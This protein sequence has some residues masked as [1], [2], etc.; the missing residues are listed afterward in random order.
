MN[1]VTKIVAA[2]PVAS[3]S[4]A[5]IAIKGKGKA[6]REAAYMQIAPLSFVEALSRNESVANLRVAL[7]VS[8]SADEVKAAQV[9]WVIGRVASRL[10][11]DAFPKGD[12]S[13]SAKLEHARNLVVSYASPAQDGKAARA[14]RKG[15]LGRRTVTQHKVIRAAEEAWSLI[16]AELGQ[17]NAQTQAQRNALKSDS[18]KGKGAAMAG[19][20]K[21]K[22][23]DLSAA[24]TTPTHAELVKPSV[25]LSEDDACSYIMTQAATLLAYANK[26]AKVIPTDFGAAI[27]ALKSAVNK[28]ENARQVRKI[29]KGS[30]A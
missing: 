26:N 16:K 21:G 5:I 18:V 30:E 24:T 25:A 4:N 29:A 23:N 11:A 10:P 20:G 27:Q 22:R 3:K 12:M 15:Q 8:P 14:L 19:A 28:A 6:Q 2:A 13:N 7:G 9:E 1:A 17:G